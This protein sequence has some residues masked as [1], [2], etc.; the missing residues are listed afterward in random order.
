[1]KK[2]I[3]LLVTISS[4]AFA[5]D[6]DSAFQRGQSAMK[7]GR[8]HEACDAYAKSEQLAARAE[9]EVAL[10]SCYEQDGKPASAARMY[11]AAGQAA[12]AAKLEARAPK[13]RFAISPTVPG[14]IVKVDGVVVSATED[15][16][17]DTGPHEVI[18]TAPGFAGHA[19]APVDREKAIL[20]VIVRMEPVAEPAP[21]PA[22]PAPAKTEPAPAAPAP[23][24][25]PTAMPTAEHADHRKRNGI[26]VG[27]VGLG[28]LVGA[29]VMF[30]ESSSKFDD[31]QKLCP[32]QTCANNADLAKGHSLLS[33]GHTLRGAAIGT[34]IAGALLVAAG[35]YLW[36]TPHR[37][38]GVAVQLDRSGG[39]VSYTARF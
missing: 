25:A 15:A 33:D 19:S 34:S 3:L 35:T 12:K 10:A 13:L 26:I 28:A 17:V 31:A 21:A 18:A 22:A 8:V 23:E 2:T 29:A 30:A 6:A 37:E 20:D 36:M 5:D 4:V 11:R 16:L 24:A 27:A 38:T 7:A 1:M 9:T 39:G 14:V 32:A